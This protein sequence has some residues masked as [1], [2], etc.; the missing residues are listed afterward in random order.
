MKEININK[1]DYEVLSQTKLP[2]VIKSNKDIYYYELKRNIPSYITSLII[3][4]QIVQLKKNM[5][6]DLL[7]NNIVA[8]E[9]ADPGYDFIFSYNID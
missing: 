7:K 6:F 4:G 2:D 9:N 3:T 5:N 8:I 1:K